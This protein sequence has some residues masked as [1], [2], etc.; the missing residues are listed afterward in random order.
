MEVGRVVGDGPE[1][2]PPEAR[3]ATFDDDG[4]LC[5]EK[6]LPIQP[7]FILRRLA[8]MADADERLRTRQPG[9]PPTSRT[10]PG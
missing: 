10:T 9:G 5:C 2:V 7:A 8:A 1:R 4:T 6:P 3:V